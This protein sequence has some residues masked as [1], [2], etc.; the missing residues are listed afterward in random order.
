MHVVTGCHVAIPGLGTWWLPSVTWIH[1]R[2]KATPTDSRDGDGTMKKNPV[3]LD[4]HPPAAPATYIASFSFRFFPSIL[5][6]DTMMWPRTYTY[7]AR[8][9]ERNHPIIVN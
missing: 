2:A 8:S 4:F 9:S 5:V 3:A 6:Y 1:V 7:A